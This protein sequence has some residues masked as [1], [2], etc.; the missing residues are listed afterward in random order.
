MMLHCASALFS[1]QKSLGIIALKFFSKKKIIR[2]IG[3][4]SERTGSHLQRVSFCC[5]RRWY[6]AAVDT[7][8]LWNQLN[9]ISVFFC[10]GNKRIELIQR[11]LYIN[12][13]FK[14]FLGGG[15][16]L[17]FSFGWGYTVLIWG[18]PLTRYLHL[19]IFVYPP[20]PF[21]LPFLIPHPLGV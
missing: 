4:S 15:L 6:I 8:N 10:F 9:L 21:H 11:Q 16:V 19:G 2:K 5:I 7:I 13:K 20:L 1:A 18:D 14:L 17:W 3:T 12:V